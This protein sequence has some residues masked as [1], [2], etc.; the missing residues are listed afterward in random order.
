[1]STD[2]ALPPRRPETEEALPAGRLAG[3][4]SRGSGVDQ[5]AA[6]GT[7]TDLNDAS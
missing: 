1:M 5:A 7:G 6:T 3:E 2:D 4:P